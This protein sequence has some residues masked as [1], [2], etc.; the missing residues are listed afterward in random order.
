MASIK[1]SV[2]EE[3]HLWRFLFPSRIGTKYEAFIYKELTYDDLKI[4]VL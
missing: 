1:D 2:Y 3:F 4:M